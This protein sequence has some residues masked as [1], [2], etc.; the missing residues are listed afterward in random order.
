MR[1]NS[2]EIWVQ[3]GAQ[4]S[5]DWVLSACARTHAERVQRKDKA[6]ANSPTGGFA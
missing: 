6:E 2:Q 4:D 3:L 1:A 5:Q